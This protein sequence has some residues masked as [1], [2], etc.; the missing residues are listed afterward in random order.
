MKKLLIAFLFLFP[1]ATLMPQEK[2]FGLGFIIGE[3]TGISAK[4]WVSSKNALDFGL[5]YSFSN[6]H[7]RIN[8]HI[9]YVWHNENLIRS[10]ERLPV[11]FGI[12]GKFQ[13]YETNNSSLG[14]RGVLG[15]MW[16]PRKLPIDIFLEVAP[17]LRIVP[18][19]DFN[20]DAGLG[21]RYYF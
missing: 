14:I 17:I 19:T 7:N 8:L 2:G 12:G 5:G 16:Y 18:A 15:L 3:P 13:S 4:Y 1:I 9:D 20:I 21:G 10:A 6:R 11:Y